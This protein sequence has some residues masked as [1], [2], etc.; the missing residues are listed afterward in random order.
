MATAVAL[1]V[2]LVAL[3]QHGTTKVI[4]KLPL[5]S[6]VVDCPLTGDQSLVMVTVTL[7]GFASVTC[8]EIVMSVVESCADEQPSLT[9]AVPG[10]LTSGRP[11]VVVPSLPEVLADVV[12]TATGAVNTASRRLPGWGAG[13]VAGVGVV[14]LLVLPE[15]V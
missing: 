6:A 14:V 2:E 15:V 12:A 13:G 5:A 1:W 4:E 10:A 7:V 9:G 11:E 3:V 8:P